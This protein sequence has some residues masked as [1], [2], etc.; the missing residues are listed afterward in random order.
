MDQNL[1]WN[2]KDKECIYFLHIPKTAGTTFYSAI[3]KHFSPKNTLILND[4]GDE[5]NEYF[6]STPMDER[7]H[8]KF[9]RQHVDYSYYQYF[10]RKLVYITMLRNPIAR[11][12]SFYKHVLRVKDHKYHARVVEQNI[13]MFDFATKIATNDVSNKQ[14]K[15]LVGG[16][17][18]E[19]RRLSALDLLEIA[20]MRLHE[21]AFFGL[22][23]RFDVSMQLLAYTFGWE[24][25]A[26]ISKNQAPQPNLISDLTQREMDVLREKNVLDLELYDYA[27]KLFEQRVLTFLN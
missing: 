21:F 18:K 12:Q 7:E 3:Q 17:A 15:M 2:L 10:S 23:E 25:L 16:K 8:L 14:V 4:E 1:K 6:Q 24:T 13:D 20:K 22:T 27:T 19:Q 11:V 26:Y 9:C 5:I